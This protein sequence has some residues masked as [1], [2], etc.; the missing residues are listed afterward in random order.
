MSAMNQLSFEHTGHNNKQTNMLI[1][2][3]SENI[4]A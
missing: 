2:L 3:Q 1:I 4:V